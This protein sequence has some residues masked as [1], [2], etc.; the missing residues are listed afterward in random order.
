MV[1][2]NALVNKLN[3]FVVNYIYHKFVCDT[4]VSTSVKSSNITMTKKK[5]SI[6]MK[7]T[8]NQ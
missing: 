5:K 7:E 4:V 1:V 3:L 6:R 8:L 2:H